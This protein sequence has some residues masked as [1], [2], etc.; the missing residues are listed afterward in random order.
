MKAVYID[1]RSGYPRAYA[2]QVT[3]ANHGIVLRYAAELPKIP[4]NSRFVII[5]RTGYQGNKSSRYC[6]VAGSDVSAYIIGEMTLN[7]SL[8]P[9][10]S[11]P[12]TIL[13]NVTWK[14]IRT[15]KNPD[16][17]AASAVLDILKDVYKNE[18]NELVIV[19]GQNNR[20]KAVVVSG[21]FRS[22][23]YMNLPVEHRMDIVN[24]TSAEAMKIMNNYYRKYIG[25]NV[26]TQEKHDRLRAKALA[27]LMGYD[28]DWGDDKITPQIAR[29][30]IKRLHRKGDN[31]SYIHVF[32]KT[33]HA[34]EE[35]KKEVEE[36]AK[37]LL[38]KILTAIYVEAALV[39]DDSGDIFTWLVPD[40]LSLSVGDRFGVNTPHGVVEV[41][42]K[43]VYKGMPSHYQKI[44]LPNKENV[45]VRK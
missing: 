19:W 36:I 44:V 21:S 10:E 32:T 30:I 2:V 8:R 3:D 37:D 18:K 38:N 23:E 6:V 9:V 39:E 11:R 1:T 17:G 42:V 33:E 5:D 22:L 45:G 43:K 16:K 35:K 41:V 27:Y 14:E 28:T 12:V 20:T 24:R 26:P 25:Q 7:R 15:H 13:E 31:L 29:E 34:D 40:D 4:T